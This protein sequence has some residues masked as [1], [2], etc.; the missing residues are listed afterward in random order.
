MLDFMFNDEDDHK[1]EDEKALEETR[2]L[3]EHHFFRFLR[4]LLL[5]VREP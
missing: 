3:E 1:C 2:S 5:Y 4:S